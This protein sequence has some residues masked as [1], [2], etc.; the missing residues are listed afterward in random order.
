MLAESMSATPMRSGPTMSDSLFG[1]HG[2]AL[3]SRSQRMGSSTSNIANAGT[4]G[5]K[6]KDID[7]Q[8]ASKARATGASED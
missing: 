7:F 8:A 2:K 3:E 1:I 4:P 5:Y 6:A